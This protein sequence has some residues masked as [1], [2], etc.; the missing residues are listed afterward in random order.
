MTVTQS[1]APVLNR[2]ALASLA[3]A[4]LTVAS[5]CAG[6]API[7]FTGFVCFPAAAVLGLATLASG[8]WSLRRIRLTGERGRGLALV[9]TTVGGVA[10][11]ALVCLL[12]IGV[13]LYPRIV[14]I[15]QRIMR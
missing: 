14:E 4:V 10:V 15:A 1:A 2:W 13:M 11:L 12:G 3:G 5:V 6:A 7:P 8:L 9:A